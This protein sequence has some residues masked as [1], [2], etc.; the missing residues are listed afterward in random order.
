MKPVDKTRLVRL[1]ICV[2]AG[3][4]AACGGGGGG[5][6]PPAPTGPVATKADAV[7]AASVALGLY[8]VLTPDLDPTAAAFVEPRFAA[9]SQGRAKSVPAKA[10]VQSDCDISGKR[11]D[12]VKEGNRTYTLFSNSVV[13]DSTGELT[14]FFDCKETY[15]ATDQSTGNL[16]RKGLYEQGS[17]LDGESDDYI[18]VKFGDNDAKYSAKFEELD[19]ATPAQ[20]VN[21]FTYEIS[22]LIENGRFTD[23]DES[24]IRN[25]AVKHTQKLGS[26]AATSLQATLGTTSPLILVRDNLGKMSIDGPMEFSSSVAGCVGGAVLV[27]TVTPLVGDAAFTA[28]EMTLTSMGVTTRLKFNNNGSVDVTVNNGAAQNVSAGEFAAAM[29]NSGC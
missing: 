11:S 17:G 24:R 9:K 16:T 26:A 18:H 5:D 7:R 19:D 28:G 10:P 8:E 1:A 20:V 14:S 21:T 29:D 22:G 2:A 27:D 25:L 15:E 12:D 3:S 13:V 6:A 23:R 4:L